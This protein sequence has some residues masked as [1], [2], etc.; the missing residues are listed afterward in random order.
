MCIVTS[1][2]DNAIGVFIPHLEETRYVSAE[3]LTPFTGNLSIKQYNKKIREV[4]SDF[5]GMF[6][7]NAY[8]DLKFDDG[9]HVFFTSDT[10]FGHERIL[11]FSQ[12]PFSSIEEMNEKIIE[13]WNNKVKEDDVVFHLG[14]FCWGGGEM[15][16]DIL[17]R[18]NGH[19]HLIVGNHDVKNM[20]KGFTKH[21]ESISFQRQIVVEGRPIY[22]NHYP[23]LTWGGLYRTED[24]QVWQLFGHVH[25]KN[26]YY[27][28]KDTERVK[29]LLPTQMDVGVDST[30]DYA[31]YSW[32]EVKE[33][34]EKQIKESKM[35]LFN[36]I[37]IGDKYKTRS[38]K[39]AVVSNILDEANIILDLEDGSQTNVDIYG[40]LCPGMI[41][42]NDIVE[43][44]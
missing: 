8:K 12:R 30:K 13:A 1:I 2:T 42:D 31:P 16:N 19:I 32:K 14:D 15:W 7:K 18:L 38:G 34:I 24:T 9:S 43:K 26:R 20:R 41:N 28:E 25:S 4:Y 40:N 17:N 10:H 29:Y 39:I 6:T 3:E 11:Q 44:I 23:L 37:K 33:Q 22:L 5:K 36:D 35:I 21:F 27:A